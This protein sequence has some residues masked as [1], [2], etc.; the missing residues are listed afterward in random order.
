M[1]IKKFIKLCLS[2]ARH[3]ILTFRTLLNVFNKDKFLVDDSLKASSDWLLKSQ[4]QN[5]DFGYSRKYSLLDN[6]DDSYIETT[7]YIIPSLFNVGIYFED[8]K[9]LISSKN[10]AEWLLKIQ[11]EDG[12]FTDIDKYKPQVF[13]TGQV[14]IGLN[15]MFNETGDKRFMK[16]IDKSAQWLLDQQDDNGC[17]IKNSY[18]SRPHTYYTRVAGAI[19]ESGYLLNNK[20][21]VRAALKNLDWALNQRRS[22]NFF[23]Y[24]EFKEEEPAILHTIVYILEGYSCAYNITKDPKW[25]EVLLVGGEQLLSLV[26]KEG[27]LYSQYDKEWKI[28]NYEY[29]ITGLAQLAGIFYDLANHKESEIFFIAAN[30]I[31]E[32]LFEIQNRDNNILQGALPSSLPIWG[33]YGGMEF[34][35]WN[36]KFFIDAVL[37]KIILTKYSSQKIRT[38][39]FNSLP[40]TNKF[41]I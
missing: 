31:M 16:A 1:T 17:W 14:L 41:R 38:Y 11:H 9:Y 32:K 10:A 6:W 40:I 13:D 39:Y 18:N 36:S 24:S 8:S 34:F 23:N 3:P 15:F 21:Y 28:T 22:N 26:N 35:N 20:S 5:D 4:Q 25:L 2:L 37:K 27:L 30:K 29:C 7:G 33:Y 19:L 12:Y